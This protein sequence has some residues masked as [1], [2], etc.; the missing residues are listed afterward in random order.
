MSQTD[1]MLLTKTVETL[2]KEQKVEL[3]TYLVKSL[4]E[5]SN[6]KLNVSNNDSLMSLKG[7]LKECNSDE[8][9]KNEYMFRR[10]KVWEYF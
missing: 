3:I 2:D 1:F 9:L 6:E 5:S 8:N 7:I 4:S 10:Y